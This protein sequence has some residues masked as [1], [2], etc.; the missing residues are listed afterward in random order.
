[1]CSPS[2]DIF[3]ILGIA[4]K[5]DSYTDLIAYAFQCNADFLARFVRAVAP[6]WS[7]IPDGGWQCFVRRSVETKGLDSTG[8]HWP[9]KLCPDLTLVLPEHGK[10]LLIE[11]QIHASA[12]EHQTKLYLR[13]EFHQ[14]LISHYKERIQNKWPCQPQVKC[15]YLSLDGREQLKG[16]VNVRHADIV[17]WIETTLPVNNLGRLLEEYRRRVLEHATWSESRLDSV[18]LQDY[19]IPRK[20]ITEEQLFLRLLDAVEAGMIS[21]SFSRVNQMVGGNTGAGISWFRGWAKRDWTGGDFETKASGKDAYR[22]Q[23]TLIW[24]GPNSQRRLE[25]HLEYHCDMAKPRF[26]DKPKAFQDEYLK[27]RDIFCNALQHNKT[28]M[29]A[30]GWC[31]QKEW[32]FL[33]KKEFTLSMCTDELIAGVQR[34]IQDTTPIVDNLLDL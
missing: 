10:V 23:Y 34:I 14:K 20:L 22:L 8:V 21:R 7:E 2:D 1:M 9:K 25:L 11:N 29:E 31:L 26:K 15:V 5:E 24:K 12:G 33:A 17:K 4:T 13:A 28:R 30:S 6:E 3:D 32:Y 16:F 18:P 19:F 27:R